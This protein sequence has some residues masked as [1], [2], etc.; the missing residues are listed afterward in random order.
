MQDKLKKC[1]YDTDLIQQE[2]E[3]G[4]KSFTVRIGLGMYSHLQEFCHK[5]AASATEVA[6]ILIRN[7]LAD[8][9]YDYQK[10]DLVSTE[11]LISFKEKIAQQRKTNSKFTQKKAYK[12]F[13]Y[14]RH[15][16]DHEDSLGLFNLAQKIKEIKK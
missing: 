15:L 2:Y 6:R 8:H 12:K 10:I 5:Y 13:Y 7:L 11:N 14:K 4:K 9:G 3:S 1:Q 16:Q